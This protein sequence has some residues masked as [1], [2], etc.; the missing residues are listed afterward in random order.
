[1]DTV[2]P[3]QSVMAS[4]SG[5]RSSESTKVDVEIVMLGVP[6]LKHMYVVMSGALRSVGR[7]VHRGHGLCGVSMLT[8]LVYAM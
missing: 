1:M 4:K 7:E 3:A 8:M 6:C 2:P 5:G